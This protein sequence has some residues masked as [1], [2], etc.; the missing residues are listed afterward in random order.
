MLLHLQQRSGKGNTNWTELEPAMGRLAQ[1]LSP[2]D[3][4]PV[5]SATGDDWWVE[6]GPVDLCSNIVTI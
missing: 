3:P 2:D 6:L 4:R 1:I 5:L